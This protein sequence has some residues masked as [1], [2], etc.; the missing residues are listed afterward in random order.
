MS[1]S[2]LIRGARLWCGPGASSAPQDLLVREGRLAAIG[3]ALAAEPGLVEEDGRGCLALPGLVDAHAH[4][5]KTLWG[6]PWHPHR[7]GPSLRDKISN[8]RQVLRE[9]GLSPQ[10]QSAR[11]L[12]HML[13][14]GTTH[15]RSHVDVGP[16]IG[17][18]HFHGV[19]AMRE[20]HRALMD[21][22]IVAFPQTGVMS[23]PGTLAL[24]EQAAR[25]GAEL[26]GGLDPMGLDH[27]PKGQLDGLFAI[28]GRHGCGLDI[29][30]HDRAELG[31]AT[32]EMVAERSRALGLRG[33]VALSHAF[34]L[35]Q[36]E[37]ARLEALI[38]LLLGE[39]IAVMTHAPSGPTAF[40][41]VRLLAE[42]GV[43]LFSG[44]D[45]VRDTW[46]PLNN[47][48]MLERA[49]LIAYRCGF[50]DDP[51]IELALALCSLGGARALGAAGY[52]LAV[53]DR[54]DLL[55]VEA[56]TA[57]EAVV[58]H[59]PRRL[60]LKGGRVVARDGRALV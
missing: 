34:C 10:E 5:D 31:A 29:H 16:E 51:G 13:A 42:R 46:S 33:R 50:R 26:I 20:Q 59:P 36:V 2:L 41:P 8:E 23:A 12:R 49:Y 39:D 24:L 7:A 48:D 6:Q 4:M 37:P 11:L 3:P 52:G 58:M 18:A 35:G 1:S 27:D 15:A 40:P 38:D 47:G 19:Q 55:L 25:E 45:G 9:L 17:L 60:V 28:A 56:G 22:E 32:I 21:I 14:R 44:S 43:R 57:A 30:L 53:G 54:A